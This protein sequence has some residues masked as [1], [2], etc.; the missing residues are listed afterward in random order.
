MVK[1][2]LSLSQALTKKRVKSQTREGKTN[3]ESAVCEALGLSVQMILA[4]PEGTCTAGD[5]R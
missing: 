3:N 5:F 2:I 1:K 4:G